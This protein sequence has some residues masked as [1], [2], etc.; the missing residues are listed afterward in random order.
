[1]KGGTVALICAITELLNEGIELKGDIIFTATAGEETDSV[2]IKRFIEEME[3][4]ADSMGPIAGVIIPEP[5]NFEIVTAHRGMLWLQATTKGKTA[6][7]SMPHLGVNALLKMNSLINRLT[8][9]PTPPM[10]SQPHPLLGESSMSINQIHA[11]KAVNV[12]PDRCSI[13]IDCRTTPNR[14]RQDILDDFQTVFA[15]LAAADKNFDAEIEIIRGVDPLLTDT[16]SEFVKSFCDTTGITET[17]A[18]GFTTDGP[19]FAELGAPVIIFGPGKSELCHKPDEYID[20]A[21]LERG[22][23]IFKK[24][25]LDLLV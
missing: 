25:I 8:A 4:N 23:Q 10:P 5:T 3:K 21:D 11:G 19:F 9:P 17:K 18:V 14:T 15:E 7:G 16:N 22:K 1:M 24:I 6:H 13:Q 2:G 20:I 12:I